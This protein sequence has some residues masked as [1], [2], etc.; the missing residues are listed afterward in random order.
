MLW[1]DEEMPRAR[2]PDLMGVGSS[3]GRM[4]DGRYF[5]FMMTDAVDTPTPMVQTGFGCYDADRE[6]LL[7]HKFV[8]VPE[9]EVFLAR[10]CFDLF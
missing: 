9:Y 2:L 5:V 3:D 8:L 6:F 7:T 10:I 4:E 1:C